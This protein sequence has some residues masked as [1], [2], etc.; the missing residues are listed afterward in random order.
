MDMVCRS[1]KAFC[2]D[3][4]QLNNIYFT[5][6]CLCQAGYLPVYQ[7]Y[8]DYYECIP[9]CKQ[10]Y[11]ME[12]FSPRMN[13][14]CPEIIWSD[15]Y[16]RIYKTNDS[17]EDNLLNISYTQQNLTVCFNP[18]FRHRMR[19]DFFHNDTMNMVIFLSNHFKS[20]YPH[21]GCVLHKF[22]QGVWC[23][24]F[25]LLSF[26]FL[27]PC[28]FIQYNKTS[29][30][31]IFKSFINMFVRQPFDLSTKKVQ[32]SI[33]FTSKLNEENVLNNFTEIKL[34]NHQNPG[35]IF[36]DLDE[37]L[38]F[39]IEDSVY[40][41]KPVNLYVNYY[42]QNTSYKYLSVDQCSLSTLSSD[43]KSQKIM[44]FVQ[45][46]YLV[47]SSD[48]V[49]GIKFTS[50]QLLT[51]GSFKFSL[52]EYLQN[53]GDRSMLR[54]TSS[55]SGLK[56]P[57][58]EEIQDYLYSM[59]N[60]TTISG[61]Q[62][63]CIFRVCQRYEWCTWS[64]M[65]ND[66]TKLTPHSTY[67]LHK[68]EDNIYPEIYILTKTVHLKIFWNS[69]L[70]S[71]TFAQTKSTN[72]KCKSET[73]CTRFSITL[74]VLIICLISGII[75]SS[76]WYYHNILRCHSR[77]VLLCCP[78]NENTKSTRE[79]VGQENLQNTN[80]KITVYHFCDNPI[81][82]N[83]TKHNTY[84]AT[85]SSNRI[86]E[87]IQNTN[88]RCGKQSCL[89]DHR[90]K[91][92]YL[93]LRDTIKSHSGTIDNYKNQIFFPHHLQHPTKTVEEKD[94]E[95]D[96]DWNK[97]GSVTQQKDITVCDSE[98]THY[99]SNPFVE[100]Q[101]KNSQIKTSSHN[102]LNTKELLPLNCESR[103]FYPCCLHTPW[104]CPHSNQWNITGGCKEIIKP[105]CRTEYMQ[106][107]NDFYNSKT[108]VTAKNELIFRN[109]SNK[110]HEDEEDG[111]EEMNV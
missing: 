49:T 11:P 70:P 85:S 20:S 89:T 109:G 17:N 58:P 73:V 91:S 27:S 104:L 76:L 53:K 98:S 25:N 97:I 110:E 42:H 80:K 21:D 16:H 29:R 35:H 69:S 51:Y 37:N 99:Y 54:N 41:G 108:V 36:Q 30:Q 13:C 82:S 59:K 22:E 68:S 45:R 94:Y 52:S 84:C 39:R 18:L 105:I 8:L 72:L 24:T 10:C 47:H 90:P 88:N 79:E 44:I 81:T 9:I 83:E 64:P 61:L 12:R 95:I 4:K 103:M 7:N 23:K 111:E 26:D 48:N 6:Q 102:E 107:N 2:S 62:I 67:H 77:Y 106:Y 78:D 60:Y 28:A 15:D 3:E 66:F 57:S 38:K 50:D 56:S 55:L 93:Q 40:K 19:L 43:I 34:I 63:N 75:C 46:N 87:N 100:I 71:S 32:Y 14:T 33:S 101:G 1:S 86:V 92:E 96:M 31:F 5:P 74:G 65:I